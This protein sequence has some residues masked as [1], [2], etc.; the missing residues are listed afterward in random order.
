M[1]F[2][3]VIGLEIHV[4]IKTKTKMF[5]T[6]PINFSMPPN[7]LVAP[8]DLAFPGTLPRVNKS[9]V[10]KAIQLSDALH[11]DI[12][13][14]L[15]FDRKNYF[16]S[17]LP[18][19]YQI[20]QNYRPIGREGYL[21]LV[22]ADGRIK[23]VHIERLHLE[24]DTAMQHHYA[25]KTLLD[26]NRAG[27]PLVEI[28]THPD[29]STGEEAMKYVEKI[30]EIVTYAD[31]SD[32][33][34]EEG[35]LRCDVNISLRPFGSEK[36]GT[37][38]EIKN[39]NSIANVQKAIEYETI[40]QQ[41]MLLKGE[42][43][44]QETRRFD[45]TKKATVR[46]RVKTDAV[47]YKY[48]PEANIPPIKLSE[49]FVN[50]AI[51]KRPELAE[52]KRERYTKKY[53]LRDYDADILLINRQNAAYFD[54]A[55]QY[56]QAYQTL[57]N[58]VNG[59][60]SAY[61]NKRQIEISQL[62]IAAHQLAELINLIEV[63]KLSNKQGRQVFELMLDSDEHPEAIAKK[64]NLLQLSDPNI[65]LPIVIATLSENP[66]SVEDYKAGKDRALGFIV[67]Q[68]MKK[69]RGQ[70]NPSLVNQIVTEE[71]NKL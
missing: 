45:E 59:E 55:A 35:S 20:T 8:L 62:T 38:V 29:L 5:S 65:I 23:R 42:A 69:M 36:L 63:G 7:T 3:A 67:G 54:D 57:A 15:H 34:M 40:R 33:K 19:G 14:E 56:T 64:H 30:R 9:A 49:Q 18:K 6:A 68:V 44:I 46:M 13:H 24:E 66:Q 31:V 60:V 1:N 17:D 25:N 4:E 39:L 61:L 37:K 50:N 53:N 12:D 41:K 48:F 58:W 27:I 51:A 22:L 11:M 43:I 32:G 28:V 16:Y 2:Q 52:Q 70:A 21:D 47:D 26:F 10:E 71:I